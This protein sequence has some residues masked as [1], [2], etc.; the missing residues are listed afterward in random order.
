M[1]TVVRGLAPSLLIALVGIAL[2]RITVGSDVFLQYV[3]E[4]LRYP[5]IASGLVLLGVGVAGVVDCLTA[6]LR[7]PVTRFGRDAEGNAVRPD[8]EE[9]QHGHDHGPR[10]AWLLTVPVVLLLCFTPPALGSFTASRDG[11]DA[12]MEQA[13]YADLGPQAPAIS[14]PTPMS[15]TEFIGRSRDPRKSLQNRKVRLTGFVAP[16]SGPDEWYLN[17]LVVSCC[18]AD[19]RRLRV[20]VHAAGPAP[21]ADTWVDLIGVWRPVPEAPANTA[22]RLDVTEQHAVPQPRAPYRDLPPS[23]G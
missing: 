19:A 4:G 10:V 6:R 11:A 23:D 21:A 1:K 13:S 2:L 18:A 7:E 16:G 8:A 12:T 9:E 17:R 22:P 5:L 3:K 14:V 20:L 15:L